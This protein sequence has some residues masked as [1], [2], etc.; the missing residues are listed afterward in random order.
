[1]TERL[2]TNQLRR[3]IPEIEKLVAAAT[4][5]DQRL[6]SDGV[7]ETLGI[8]ACEVEYIIK[9]AGMRD[10][11]GRPAAVRKLVQVAKRTRVNTTPAQM[12]QRIEKIERLVEDAEQQG[13]SLSRREL[14]TNLQIA[15]GDLDYILGRTTVQK[16]L[17]K[18]DPVTLA[19][20]QRIIQFCEEHPEATQAQVQRATGMSGV[21][22][23]RTLDLAEISDF[24]T[25]K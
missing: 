23:R 17:R 9:C 21:T 7:A 4:L 3:R 1:M 14:A 5:A 18:S 11:L 20:K 24:W 15:Q 25:K 8:R 12:Q 2:P 19:D 22:I 6:S 16:K 10:L 13:K